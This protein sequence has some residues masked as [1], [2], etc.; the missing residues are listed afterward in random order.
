MTLKSMTQLGHSA[1]DLERLK[2]TPAPKTTSSFLTMPN[3][4][5][6]IVATSFKV[7]KVRTYLL[8]TLK[9]HQL[10]WQANYFANKQ[11]CLLRS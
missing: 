6:D 2:G 8:H 1:P 10:Y 7:Q 5:T 3:T 11:S 9:I 4:T